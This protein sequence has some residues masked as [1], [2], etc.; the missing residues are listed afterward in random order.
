[1]TKLIVSF[2]LLFTNYL[3]LQEMYFLNTFPMFLGVIVFLLC[4]FLLISLVSF[5]IPSFI[6]TYLIYFYLLFSSIINYFKF[7]YK[8]VISSTL[9]QST[10]HTD[11]REVFELFNI[12]FFIW[13]VLTGVLP[14]VLLS[15]IIKHTKPYSKTLRDML[16]IGLVFIVGIVFTISILPTN[17]HTFRYLTNA[18]CSFMPYNYI[19]GLKNYWSLYRTNHHTEDINNVFAFNIEEINQKNLNI[20]LVI[21][22]SSRADR[23]GLNGYKRNTTPNLEGIKNLISYK[24][25][26]SLATNTPL[27]VQA[28]M[29]K[30][31]HYELSSFIQIF[32]KLNF[33]THWLSN[34][35]TRYALI[36]KIAMESP[37]HIFSDDIRIS[38]IG[39]NYDADLIPFVKDIL[40]TNKP[41]LI[42]LHTMGSHRLYDLRYPSE[43][44]IFSPTCINNELYYATNECLDVEKLGNSYDNTIIYTDYFLSELI[45]VLENSNAILLYIS[46]HGES[47]GEDGIYAHSHPFEL[48]PIEQKHIPLVMWAS[49]KFLSNKT[50]LDKFSKAGIKSNIKIDQS[51]IFHSLLDCVGVKSDAI[52]YKKSLCN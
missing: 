51:N 8:I 35:S 48:A 26:Y 34:Q 40:L 16:I 37:H 32:N 13:F 39:N 9:V 27:G 10:V 19:I 11:L 24:E 2:V 31:G 20:V 5:I 3:F 29:K 23:W 4:S 33:T 30:D 12:S 21:G 17:V 43:F 6:F 47:L 38:N 45:K 28:I 7:Y 42:V 46:D 50:N 41:N 15:I 44:K 22:E 52:D 18:L 49:E 36:N 14:C 25:T 1:M